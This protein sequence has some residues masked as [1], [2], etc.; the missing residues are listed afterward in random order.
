[1]SRRDKALSDEN[2]VNITPS[3]HDWDSQSHEQDK[4]LPLSLSEQRKNVSLKLSDV[5][6]KFETLQ[7]VMDSFKTKMRTDCDAVFQSLDKK[8]WLTR[9]ELLEYLK[10]S[11]EDVES[12]IQKNKKGLMHEHQLAEIDFRKSIKTDA[13]HLKSDLDCLGRMSHDRM[14]EVERRLRLT[15]SFYRE[16]KADLNDLI[17][18]HDKTSFARQLDDGLSKHTFQQTICT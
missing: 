10:E 12:R 6:Y 9:K 17:A 8:A 2:R 16:V 15:E 7:I 1:M 14:E 11:I 4:R 18:S 3:L 5:D 13:F